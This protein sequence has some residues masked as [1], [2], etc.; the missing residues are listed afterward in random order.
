MKMQN[1]REKSTVYQFD[2]RLFVDAIK[3][4]EVSLSIA[5]W[6]YGVC[7]WV[8]MSLFHNFDCLDPLFMLFIH[9]A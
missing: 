2:F 5:R 6:K 1:R 4:S 3:L 7:V 8:L 9:R